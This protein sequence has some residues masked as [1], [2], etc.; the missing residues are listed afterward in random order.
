MF[1]EIGNNLSLEN[2]LNLILKNK[3]L[4]EYKASSETEVWE[5][6]IIARKLFFNFNSIKYFGFH[7]VICN[8]MQILFI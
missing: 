4:A 8:Y 7:I 6:F 2:R 3:I 5:T 1:A